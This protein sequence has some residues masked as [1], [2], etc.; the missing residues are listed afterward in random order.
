MINSTLCLTGNIIGCNIMSLQPN[1]IGKHIDRTDPNRGEVTSRCEVWV[2]SQW[3]VYF[4]QARPEKVGNLQNWTQSIIILGRLVISWGYLWVY[5]WDVGLSCL[6][7]VNN[8]WRKQ[9]GEF[10]SSAFQQSDGEKQHQTCPSPNVQRHHQRPRC[11][12]THTRKFKLP[13]PHI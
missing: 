2:N 11:A 9:E 8:F 12:Y 6:V 1:F 3:W 5:L 4:L 7:T 10:G 13:H